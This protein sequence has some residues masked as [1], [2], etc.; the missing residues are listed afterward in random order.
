M[1]IN[2]VRH[3]TASKIHGD[4]PDDLKHLLTFKTQTASYERDLRFSDETT[5]FWDED[6]SDNSLIIS[7]GFIKRVYKSLS[8]RGYAVKITDKTNNQIPKPKYKKLG[9]KPHKWQI[10]ALKALERYPFG[11]FKIATGSGKTWLQTE[12]P[13]IYDTAKIA[14][15]GRSSSVL[16]KL[17]KNL[18]ASPIGQDVAGLG[19]VGYGKPNSRIVVCCDKSLHRLEADKIQILLYDEVHNAASPAAYEA[20]TSFVNANFFGFSASPDGRIDDRDPFIESL[21]GNV[22]LD[23]SHKD[24]VKDG[25][26]NPVE[27]RIYMCSVPN[28]NIDFINKN[29]NKQRV[30]FVERMKRGYIRNEPRNRLIADVVNQYRNKSVLIL[31][32][33]DLEHLFRMRQYL[34]DFKMVYGPESMWSKSGRYKSTYSKLMALGLMPENYKPLHPGEQFMMEEKFNKGE[35]NKVICTNIWREGVDLPGLEV[36]VRADGDPGVIPSMQASGRVVRKADKKSILID[37]RDDFGSLFLNR[38]NA[39]EKE[40]QKIGYTIKLM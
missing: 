18:K 29:G 25:I 28:I 5:E 1:R 27:A 4:W 3:G 12:I 34:P 40:Y 21:F 13:K 26:V 2:I 10:R 23:L 35:I 16:N 33:N 22:I 32:R 8:G 37:F 36:I 14:M 11:V 9:G 19:K 31:C 17:Y 30:N 24:L 38:S 6:P 39:R 15:V 20:L 7:S